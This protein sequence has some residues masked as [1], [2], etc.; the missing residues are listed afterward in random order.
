VVVRGVASVDDGITHGLV[1]VVDRH[2]STDTPPQALLVSLL[3]LLEACEVVLNRRVAAGAGNAVHALCAHLLLE[4]VVRIGQSVL[5]SLHAA[6][7]Q[8]VE[9]VTGVRDMVWLDAQESTVFDDRVLELLLLLGGVGVVESKDQLA[10]VLGVGEVVV[11]KRGL[12]VSDVEVATGLQLANTFSHSSQP[13]K[14]STYEGSGG[15]RVTIPEPSPTSC[16]PM[17]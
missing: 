5:D 1:R 8:L 13:P 7:V 14:R 16:R 6:L 17:S 4:C 11:Q 9:E 12:G 2:L 10:L 3:H 15:N